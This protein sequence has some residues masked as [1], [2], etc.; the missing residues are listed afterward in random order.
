MKYN[1]G[2]K[3]EVLNSKVATPIGAW[4]LAEITKVE[5]EKGHWFTVKYS[6]GRHSS[7]PLEN[8]TQPLSLSLSLSQVRK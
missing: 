4:C 3:V 5:D 1:V 2:S 6:S 7:S 8:P